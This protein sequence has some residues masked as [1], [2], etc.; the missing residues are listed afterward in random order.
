MMSRE[1]D[2]QRSRLVRLGAGF[3]LIC[4]IV[5]IQVALY[6]RLVSAYE[7][8]VAQVLPEDS[9]EA[10]ARLQRAI[11]IDRTNGWALWMLSRKR[12]NEAVEASDKAAA[13]EAAA[14]KAE[15]GGNRR[16]A[17]AYRVAKQGE[18]NKTA[19]ALKEAETLAN[20]G[21]R[22]FNAVRCYKQ[23]AS[24]YLRQTKT[25][26]GEE[27]IEATERNL[28]TVARI[29]PND[30]EAIERLGLLKLHDKKW[31][32][33]ED[34]CAR[35][36]RKHP[37]SANAYFYRAFIA[38]ET[39]PETFFLNLRQAYTMMIQDTGPIFFNRSQLESLAIKLGLVN[40]P[41]AADPN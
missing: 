1:A 2:P 5:T 33:L 34:L 31:E 29:K 19:A 22:Y 23:L 40:Q 39:D 25:E 35:I 11:R 38:R 13:L 7:T 17:N 21:A 14:V 10:E 3:L 9:D 26:S 20:K 16:A 37:Y 8:Q 4:G 41:P 12:L 18:A 30:I 32:E 27:N 36:L 15:S 6:S 28:Q 24:I